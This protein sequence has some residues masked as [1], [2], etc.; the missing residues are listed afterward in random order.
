MTLSINILSH[1]WRGPKVYQNQSFLSWSKGLI[2]CVDNGSIIGPLFPCARTNFLPIHQSSF[3]K[4][5]QVVSGVF[6]SKIS[7]QKKKKSWVKIL[8]IF[9]KCIYN[10]NLTQEF[11][12]ATQRPIPGGLSNMQG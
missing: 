9:L 5:K 11:D 8:E 2:D 3:Y 12:H 1:L 4:S 7:S 6:S 10:F